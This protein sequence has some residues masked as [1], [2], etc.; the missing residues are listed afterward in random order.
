MK[1]LPVS[2]DLNH[3]KKQ[4]K[5]L[6]R[7]VLA[8]EPSALL[9]FVENLPAARELTP[10]ELTHRS[11]KLHDAQSV[12]AREY[13]FAS[14]AE[15][16]QYVAWKQSD[17]ADRL[18]QWAH[19][20]YIDQA[21]ERRLAMR[22]L[23]EEP[24]LFATEAMLK[25]PWIACATGDV[26][27]LSR[28][29]Q[30][31]KASGWVNQ[32]IGP[33]KMPPLTAVTHSQIARE[34]GFEE[35]MLAAMQL[36]LEHGANPDSSW[37]SPE[38]KD[39]PFSALYGAAGRVYSAKMTRALLQAGANPDDNESL[40]H[41]CEGA[42]AEVTLSLLDAGATVSGTNALGRVLDFDKPELLRAMIAHGGDVNE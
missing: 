42:D 40:Y 36:L 3:L 9:R 8:A 30:S 6:L 14:W 5:E 4:A 17:R 15:L 22:M 16:S 38:W 33:L 18:K 11:L 35:A 24:G 23:Q 25:E 10:A 1:T 34:P 32:P 19:W 39:N 13:G 31:A 37:M 2:P 26:A 12:I 29:L 41:S 20:V 7:E 28:V 21:R 27:V